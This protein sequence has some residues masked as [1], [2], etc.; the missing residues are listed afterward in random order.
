[1]ADNFLRR[2]FGRARKDT[3]VPGARP[4]IELQMLRPL[5]VGGV[6]SGA[7]GTSDKAVPELRVEIGTLS[8][9]GCVREVNED[10]I[11]VIRPTD[12]NE[13]ATRG[14]LVVVADG[15]GGHN[16]G[17]IA[18]R[19][20]VEVVVQRFADE[21]K[22]PGKA[23]A[24]AIEQANRVI[25]DAA[26]RDARYTGMGTTCTALLLRGG[27]AYCAHVGDSRLY[28]VRGNDIFLM[29]EDHSAV[30][31]LVRQGTITADEARHHP[32]KNVIVRALGGRADVE[33]AAWEKPLSVRPGDTFLMCSDGLYDLVE[34]NELYD[35]LRGALPQL[36]CERLVE[37]ARQRGGPDNITVGIITMTDTAAPSGN[38][39]KATRASEVAR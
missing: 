13:L 33:V 4:T 9:V 22:E 19:L 7:D 16:A 37:L 38:A 6:S 18:S 21:T 27:L 3:P 36:A 2:L 10:S 15:M 5:S 24:R 23:L 31:D 11:R 14:I 39:L 25:I 17:E 30:M 29:T 34:D 20:A 28:L 8:D 26:S 35:A 1:M 12:P 32:D